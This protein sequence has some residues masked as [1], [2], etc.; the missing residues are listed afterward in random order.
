M[1]NF[2][3]LAAEFVAERLFK[4]LFVAIMNKSDKK[5]LKNNPDKTVRPYKSVM[6]CGLMFCVIALFFGSPIIFAD[7][8]A[9][10]IEGALCL[11]IVG[12]PL[13]IF[14]AM[15]YLNIK[16]EYDSYGFTFRNIFRRNYEYGYW[17]IF[18]LTEKAYGL[19]L[20]MD[21]TRVIYVFKV[22]NGSE[23]FINRIIK[24]VEG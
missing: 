4:K 8:I 20:E 24:K 16:Y 12:I 10:K 21:D 22:Y 14:P 2:I 18:R 7:N 1:F 23:E 11:A 15:L 3:I 6:Y 19:K 17:Q 5:D 9:E 13:G